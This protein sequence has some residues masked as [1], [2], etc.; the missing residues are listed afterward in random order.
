MQVK[1]NCRKVHCIPQNKSKNFP[2]LRSDFQTTLQEDLRLIHNSNKQWLL[3]IKLLTCTVLQQRNTTNYYG[4]QLLQKE[5][6]NTKI[7]DKINKKRKESLKNKEALH[8]LDINE[9]SNCFFTLKGHKE[10]LQ[11]NPTVRLINPAKMKLGG[12]VKWF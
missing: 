2:H 4:M 12:L 11:N 7:K 10:N 3:Q 5:K 1:Q 9:G 8:W 6:T